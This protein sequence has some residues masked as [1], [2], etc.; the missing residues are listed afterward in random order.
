MG[1]ALDDLEYYVREA[2]DGM[3]AVVRDLGQDLACR[4]PALPGANSPFAIL[5]HC[6]A[7]LN[8]WGGHVVAGRE[9]SRDRAAEFA[10]SGPVADLLRAAEQAKEQF[11]ADLRAVDPGAAPRRPAAQSTW[12]RAGDLPSQGFALLHILADVAQHHGQAQLTRD[13]LLASSR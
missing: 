12:S 4:A 5:T 8:Y 9:V 3:T 7:M 10:A 1:L 11:A 6:L 13:V 2:I